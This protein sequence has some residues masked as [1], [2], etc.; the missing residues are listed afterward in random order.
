[1]RPVRPLVSLAL[2]ALL[3]L[4]A[5][6]EPTGTAE[7]TLL[8][9]SPTVSKEH[10][11][12]VYAQDLWIVG[13]EG[14]T[15]R[16]LTS[17]VGRE[18]TPKLSPD[19]R[20]VAFSGEYEGNADVYVI[21]VDGGTPRR[22][23]W[24]PDGDY[25]CG[26]HP[27]GK[28]V[29]FRSGRNG[30]PRIGRLFLASLD[31]GTPEMLAVP[32]AAHASYNAAGDRLAYT[33]WS[34]AFRTWKRY[35]GGRVPPVWIYDP[36]TH[37]VEQVPHGVASDTFPCW[38]GKDVYFASDRPSKDGTLQMNVWRYTPGSKEAPEQITRFTD[39]GV[40]GMSA[41]GGVL[42]FTVAGS[43]RVYDPKDKSFR[44]LAI[45]VPT[46]GLG[47]L[48]RWQAVKG[49][50]RGAHL[51]PNGKRAVFEARG[52][53]ITIPREH[54]APR[55]LTNSPG[56][57]QR[58]PAW[59][60]DGKR[61]AWFSDESGEY[62]LIVRDRLGR[63]ESKAYDLGGARFYD[64]PQWSPDAKHILFSDKGNRL[65]FLTLAGGAVTTVS[66]AQGT[67][68]QLRPQATWSPDSRWIAFEQRNPQTTYDSIALYEVATGS[69]T[70]L[71]D[72]FSTAD[73]P[74][75]SRDGKHLFFRASVDSG[76][77]RF[78]LDLSTSAVRRP[79]GNL[80][81]AVLKKDGEDPFGPRSDEGLPDADKKDGKKKSKG[82]AG[83]KDEPK[84]DDAA[85]DD[86][87][88]KDDG[89]KDEP[90]KPSIDL[91]GLSQRIL[92]L[93]VG[94]GTYW[95]L[96]CS[97]SQLLYVSR[98]EGD[99][100]SLQAFDLKKRKASEIM[101]GASE[102]VVSA[103]GSSLLVRAGQRWLLTNESG[104]DANNLDIDRVKVHVEP[105]KE[106]PQILRECWRIQRDFFYDP[107]LHQVDWPA[108]WER[109]SAFLPYVQHREDLNLLMGEMMGELC[110]GHEYVGG[111]DAPD[112]KGGID[113]GLLGADFAVEDGRYRITTIYE[114]QN[115]NPGM[116]APLTAPGVGVHVGDYVLAVNGRDLRSTDN[117]FAAFQ[118]TAN[119]ATEL[120]VSAHADGS[121]P[122]TYTVNPIGN[123]DMLRSRSWVEANRKRVDE[124]SG[125]RLAYV[126][127]PNT[128]GAGMAAFDRDFYS[129]LDKEGLI[130]DERFNGGGKVADY[131]IDVL[132]R[133]V[134]CYW[135]NRE[136]WLGRTP[137][138]TLEGPKVM[139]V[140]ERAGS[141]GDAMPWMFKKLRLGPIVGT[142]TW[143]GL[144]GISGYPVLMDG[145]SCT[146][147]SFG[148][149]DTDGTWAVENVGVAP[150]H[151]VIQWPKDVI[152]GHDPQLEKAVAVA[153]E[154]LAK[155][156]P[157]KLPG[158]SP[159]AKR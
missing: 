69:V 63:E 38:L 66:T 29:L 123:D 6:A 114:G 151:E 126:Y 159:P 7:E 153:L 135:M 20:W 58:S 154:M 30:G 84:E 145:G 19:G 41:G 24:H 102:V 121:E 92:A 51:S 73:S 27:D 157:K 76:P 91:E 74:A 18:A 85:E 61:I 37:D 47:R 50:V 125:G 137:F 120:T 16:R 43:I 106:W 26:W 44:K 155:N 55:N 1:M 46:D 93:P 142:R 71:T 60:P 108:M 132:G 80:Y 75:F 45:K 17:D 77:Q 82:D 146:A 111:G 101:A 90:R 118:G 3:A 139:I 150:D 62:Q 100:P 158:Y 78:G 86:D 54:G 33:P 10:I 131:V 56:T 115:W 14:G 119:E 13:R 89:K 11:V 42:A 67:L 23:T 128:A 72:G 127:M 133:Q 52:E 95:G 138:G 28:H 81:V 104:K 15:A 136:G 21:S 31:G 8:L 25:V 22:L 87:E 83:R 97:K 68:G 141:G 94:S 129:Q 88:K 96:T 103:D 32:R 9:Q 4:R 2:I 144:V 48:P 79:S 117:L 36:K 147:A 130:L 112:A 134:I 65:A 40:H 152:A 109:W 12:F 64:D 34:D 124:L 149:M 122:R 39:F 99:K 98:P 35:R 140:N 5:L 113:V 70:T 143:G 59:S 156:P 107:Q 116:R 110:C 53:I 57:N 105:D 148:I 49:F